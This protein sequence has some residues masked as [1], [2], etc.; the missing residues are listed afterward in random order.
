M[1]SFLGSLL[2]YANMLL[3]SRCSYVQR[4]CAP[5]LTQ[6]NSAFH[7]SKGLT[8]IARSLFR[9]SRAT[10]AAVYPHWV[11]SFVT[12]LPVLRIFEKI[13]LDLIAQTE[14]TFSEHLLC[15]Q[16]VT[17]RCY[18]LPFSHS[19]SVSLLRLLTHPQRNATHVRSSL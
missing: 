5:V 18:F 17:T 14:W 7:V 16:Q 8:E 1:T 10:S 15:E 12:C 4:D 11:L 9:P 13:R 3:E 6:S 2:V 19:C